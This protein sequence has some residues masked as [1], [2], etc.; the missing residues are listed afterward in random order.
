MPLASDASL[1]TAGY[2]AHVTGERGSKPLERLGESK[3]QEK[4]RLGSH[5]DPLNKA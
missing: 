4:E 2:A 1:V 3:Q 5:G